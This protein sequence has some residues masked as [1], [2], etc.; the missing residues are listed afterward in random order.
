MIDN[1]EVPIREGLRS[2][3]TTGD[4]K[5]L[6]FIALIG[7]GAFNGLATWLEKILNEAHHI[8]MV[9]AGSISAAMIFSGTLGCIL[10]PLFSDK[11]QRRKPFLIA[12]SFIGAICVIMLLLQGSFS[13]NL[14][15][16]IILGFFLLSALPIMLTMSL[17]I[18]GEKYA[19]ISVAYLQLLGNGAAVIIVPIMELLH[20]FHGGGYV[21]P[22]AFLAILLLAASTMAVKIKETGGRKANTEAIDY[23]AKARKEKSG[24]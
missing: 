13:G 18:T 16:G 17:E 8:S 7:I 11:I 10:V 14:A 6:G 3:I 4:F 20:G 5:L 19:G 12:A 22:L 23:N 15:N 1:Q 21:L 9:N 24:S 2:I